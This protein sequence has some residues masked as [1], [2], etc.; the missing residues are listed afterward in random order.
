[1]ADRHISEPNAHPGIQRRVPFQVTRIGCVT[2][3]AIRGKVLIP[4]DRSGIY[5]QK[6]GGAMTLPPC[7]RIWRAATIPTDRAAFGSSDPGDARSKDSRP[8]IWRLSFCARMFLGSYCDGY[9]VRRIDRRARTRFRAVMF[10]M[11]WGA[12]ASTASA[13]KVMAR[14]EARAD[15]SPPG[16]CARKDSSRP[17]RPR[18][19]RGQLDSCQYA[20]CLGETGISHP[21]QAPPSTCE[22]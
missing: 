17:A 5:P 11:P 19:L 9:G 21:A 22:L 3:Q 15:S 16:H 10:S 12:A 18:L 7:A 6:N 13:I 1:M 14:Q 2:P 20:P 8:S 4:V